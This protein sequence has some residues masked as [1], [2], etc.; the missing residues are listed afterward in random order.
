LWIP[1][2]DTAICYGCNANSRVRFAYGLLSMFQVADSARVYISE[3]DTPLHH[4]MS[5]RH[6]GLVTSAY[7][8][9]GSTCSPE[10]E[11][12]HEDIQGLSF[13]DG[14]L[15]AVLCLDVLEHVD[16]P[17]RAVQEIYR[18][19]GRGGLGVIT[20]PFFSMRSITV[21]RARATAD[22]TVEHIRPP[23]YHGGPHGTKSLVFHELSWDFVAQCRVSLGASF[24]FV[25]YWSL[26]EC[27]L[28]TSRFV[29]IIRK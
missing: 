2:S 24:A 28:D 16:E 19:L 15:E 12:R 3:T 20:F 1:L 7:L 23:A 26:Y 18:T 5:A 11:V 27:H 6:C 14:S 21:R 25:N 4:V 17:V 22:G 10:S 9:R 29:C 8:S 13:E